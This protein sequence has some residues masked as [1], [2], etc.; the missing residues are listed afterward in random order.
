MA[1]SGDWWVGEVKLPGQGLRLRKDIQREYLYAALVD[2][3]GNEEDAS[4]K[5]LD[6]TA[7]S[8]KS[9]WIG[10][11]PSIPKDILEI[12][13]AFIYVI[14]KCDIEMINL[15]AELSEEDEVPDWDFILDEV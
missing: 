14:D 11:V 3:F 15:H 5:Y 2:Y 4:Q 8:P 13:T 7:Y 10:D 9:V 12:Y 6:W 1:K